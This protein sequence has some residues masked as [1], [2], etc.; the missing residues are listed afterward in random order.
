M[1]GTSPSAHF[2][3]RVGRGGEVGHRFPPPDSLSEPHFL[4]HFALNAAPFSTLEVSQSIEVSWSGHPHSQATDARE[5]GKRTAGQ[6]SYGPPPMQL[7]AGSRGVKS[8]VSQPGSE[9]GSLSGGGEEKTRWRR[10][11]QP[12][13]PRRRHV[14]LHADGKGKAGESTLE[15]ESPRV[16]EGFSLGESPLC[17]WARGGGF[18][19]GGRKNQ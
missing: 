15:G 4:R 12:A 13:L 14:I 9:R 1:G 10:Q 7:T 11:Q 17:W 3:P 18:V 19:P 16:R 6:K 5:G 8:L 2:Q